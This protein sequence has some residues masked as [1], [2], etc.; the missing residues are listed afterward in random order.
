MKILYRIQQIQRAEIAVAAILAVVA[1]ALS[2]VG[3][4]QISGGHQDFGWSGGSL[5]PHWMRVWASPAPAIL[6]AF[7]TPIPALYLLIM[8]LGAGVGAIMQ[9]HP[10][11]GILLFLMGGL[12]LIPSA[13]GMAFHGLR[14]KLIDRMVASQG[15]R[16]SGAFEAQ[17]PMPPSV[18]GNR[19]TLQGSAMPEAQAEDLSQA[20]KP[21]TPRIDFS[22]LDGMDEVKIKL[23]EAGREAV[24]KGQ[25]AATGRN[26]VLLHGE[27]G[28][29]KTTFAEALAGELKVPFMQVTIGDVG[30]RWIGQTP[31]QLR[32]AFAAAQKH[33]PMV[34]FLDEV[35]SIITDRS[36]SQSNGADDR[37][38]TNVFLTEAVRLRGT[39]VVLMAATNLLDNLD[40]AAIREGRFDWKVEIPNPDYKARL[41]LLKKGVADTGRDVVDGV[42]ESLAVRWAGF[43]VSRF[44][45]ISKEIKS[46]AGAQPLT[47][48]DFHHA[49]RQIQGNADRVPESAKTLR[50]MILSG[51]NRKTLEGVVARL[52]SPFELER[53]GGTL[54]S[55]VLFVGP[56]GTGKTEAAR[57]I[58]RESGWSLV[59]TNGSELV[60]DRNQLKTIYKRACAARP[61]IVFID[62]ADDVLRDRSVSYNGQVTN[63]LL[64]IMEGTYDRVPDVVFVAATN[65]PEIIDAA[66]LRAGRF[67]EKAVFENP[68]VDDLVS[69][70]RTWSAS[71]GWQLDGD[72]AVV[73]AMLSGQSIANVRGVLDVAVNRAIANGC[74]V[75]TVNGPKVLS[76]ANVQEA[77]ETVL[78]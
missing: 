74:T 34:L 15:E 13:I 39:G 43:S 70:L 69:Y 8:H 19:S 32:A 66:L 75:T 57:A 36:D 29:G 25:G 61:S 67:T 76:I 41:G 62:E 6:A 12:T 28:N 48:V 31:E 63:E 26:G 20:F 58:A 44:R 64:T 65:N 53:Q 56:P 33:A 3:I 55:G 17:S 18:Q 16:E 10:F 7:V 14:T 38:N 50:E 30:S 23:L 45:A 49:L 4:F 59:V 35:D 60:R 52:K 54:P 47:F 72:P 22:S 40:P 5:N 42:L 9:G 78:V 77:M 2:G 46:Y 68:S 27:P 1:F 21:V 73:A 11:D 51:K 71:A 37:K 24:K